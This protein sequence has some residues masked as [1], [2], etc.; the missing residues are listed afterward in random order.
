LELTFSLDQR[1]YPQAET[2]RS[3]RVNPGPEN[4]FCD[5]YMWQYQYRN[6]CPAMGSGSVAVGQPE[7]EV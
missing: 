7:A 5:Q 1:S 4:I 2:V 3:S 6:H